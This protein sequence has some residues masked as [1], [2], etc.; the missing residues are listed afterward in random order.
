MKKIW[1]ALAGA[2]LLVSCASTPTNTNTDNPQ[3]T[4]IDADAQGAERALDNN[5]LT[6]PDADESSGETTL[7]DVDSTRMNTDKHGLDADT[8]AESGAHAIGNTTDGGGIQAIGNSAQTD[9]AVQNDTDGAQAD[10]AAQADANGGADDTEADGFSPLVTREADELEIVSEEDV[11]Q[12]EPSADDTRAVSTQLTEPAIFDA[13]D[14][15]ATN[16]LATTAP[17]AEGTTPLAQT[18]SPTPGTTGTAV[19][20]GANTSPTAESTPRATPVVQ[21]ERTAPAQPTAQSTARQGTQSSAASTPRTASAPNP[22]AQTQA[23]NTTQ[24]VAANT[25]NATNAAHTDQTNTARETQTTVPTAQPAAPTATPAP[26][27]TDDTSDALIPLEQQTVVPS[28]SVTIKN[29]QYLDVVYPGSGWVYLGEAEDNR[30]QKKNPLFSYFGRKLGTTDTTF[31]LRSR[32]AGTTLLHFYKNDA[33]T[34]QYIDDYL[35]VTVETESAKAGERATAPAYAEVVPPKPS[36]QTRQS[37]EN[38][39]STGA[40][41]ANAA[42]NNQTQTERAAQATATQGTQAATTNAS[43]TQSATQTAS[44]LPSVEDRGVKTVI[45]TTESAPNGEA[46]SITT[47]PAYNG[48][49]ENTTGG[50]AATDT[51][52]AAGE[53]D[54]D[55]LE[56]AK[57]S[58]AAKQYETAL[59][60]V[61]RYLDDAT[62]KIDEALYL[63]GQ[64]LEAESS[65]KSV[66]SAIDSYESLTKNYPMSSLWGKANNRIIYLKRFYIE[67]R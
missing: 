12:N 45:Q 46:K 15:N 36:R 14:P 6:A 55:L 31:T 35:A 39:V 10:D 37:Y 1:F 42:K 8:A 59:D 11:L 51:Q 61:Q 50:A 62:T 47:A 60:Q 19:A 29:N 41:T 52:T 43:S 7:T 2:M 32:K 54:L 25:Q 53:S 28:R 33:L 66:R 16:T 40:T 24:S 63:Q 65:V 4:Q 27:Q 9:D 23:T 64:V 34:G 57:R 38:V 58:Y 3:I 22:R 56:Q 49:Q 20:S 67:I 26:A 48:T 21:Q 30:S 17:T 18:T 5:F 13:P 44:V